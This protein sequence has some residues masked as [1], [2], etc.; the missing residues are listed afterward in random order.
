MEEHTN[1][2]SNDVLVGEDVFVLFSKW[3]VNI[4]FEFSGI[5]I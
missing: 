5:S 4:D 2:E 3:K 1:A